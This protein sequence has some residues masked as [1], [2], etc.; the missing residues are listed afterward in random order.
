MYTTGRGTSHSELQ[1]KPV[2]RSSYRLLNAVELSLQSGCNNIY[3][4][5][6][7]LADLG[8]PLRRLFQTNKIPIFMI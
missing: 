2:M 8:T 4:S 6:Y 7:F 5:G 1:Q 3:N